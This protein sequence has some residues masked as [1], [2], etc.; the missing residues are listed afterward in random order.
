MRDQEVL[1]ELEAEWEDVA[2]AVQVSA[3]SLKALA[4]AALPLMDG[5]GSVVGLDFDVVSGSPVLSPLVEPG[6]VGWHEVRGHQDFQGPYIPEAAG[7][8]LSGRVCR[9]GAGRRR[10]RR[11]R[12]RS[13]R[14]Q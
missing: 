13:A 2:T 8:R 7:A 4:M 14:G 10:G 5:G 11:G 9:G 1:H 12:C 3:Y 6:V